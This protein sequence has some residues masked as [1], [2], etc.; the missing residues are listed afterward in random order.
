MDTVS[1]AELGSDVRSDRC[2]SSVGRLSAALWMTVALRNAGARAV[3]ERAERLH[4]LMSGL[5]AAAEAME[6][7]NASAADLHVDLAAIMAEREMITA[8]RS[9]TV[10]PAAR[11][12]R[13]SRAA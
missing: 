12:V 10:R 1:P 4:N 9:R 11:R 6:L 5:S 2:E 13:T 8:G 3:A 7:E